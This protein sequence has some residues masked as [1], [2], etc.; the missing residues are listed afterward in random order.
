MDAVLHCTARCVLV[1]RDADG[2]ARLDEVDPATLAVT[3]RGR[4]TGVDV[5][6]GA[7]LS[8]DGSRVAL[9][10]PSGDGFVVLGLDGAPLQSVRAPDG[11]LVQFAA[12][13][14]H[15][16]ALIA[17]MVCPAAATFEIRRLPL[18][19]GP[20]RTLATSD[21]AWFSHP[22][23]SRDGRRLAVSEMPFHGN[24]WTLEP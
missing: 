7:A 1:G 9:H 17:T 14:P 21:I 13:A 20:S 18:G 22:V 19:A 16:D 15:G 11:C 12:F 8:P 5:G 4:A 3:R 10:T 2:A 6:F 24:V 23:V